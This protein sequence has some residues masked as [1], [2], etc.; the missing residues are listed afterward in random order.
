MED[1]DVNGSRR[2]VVS[3]ILEFVV[4]SNAFRTLEG[5]KDKGRLNGDARDNRADVERKYRSIR[6]DF[7]RVEDR[8]IFWRG[9]DG[10]RKPCGE[11]IL[12]WTNL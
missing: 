5:C 4:T 12:V 1:I 7:I 3:V 9:E 10:C 2:A 6:I 11:G 8:G